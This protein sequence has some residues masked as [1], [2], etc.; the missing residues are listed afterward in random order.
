[1]DGSTTESRN[2]VIH[3]CKRSLSS[4]I[5]SVF[6]LCLFSGCSAHTINS[7]VNVGICVE[8]L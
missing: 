3:H 6:I 4:L 7:N 8:A 1:M 2:L 5:L